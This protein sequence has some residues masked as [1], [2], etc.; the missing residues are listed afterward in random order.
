M[1]WKD[2]YT[3][4]HFYCNTKWLILKRINVDMNEVRNLISHMT[5]S[6]DSS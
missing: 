4:Q 6:K 2:I 5:A 1:K 3:S